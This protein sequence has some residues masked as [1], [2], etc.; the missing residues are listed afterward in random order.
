MLTTVAIVNWGHNEEGFVAL[1]NYCPALAT[2]DVTLAGCLGADAS[3]TDRTLIALGKGCPKLTKVHFGA[4]ENVIGDLSTV[5]DV[6]LR[7]LAER[8]RKL[9]SVS[10]VLKESMRDV[11]AVILPK[12]RI[13]FYDN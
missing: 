12:A 8:Y 1:A 2:L 13:E 10:L 3:L 6:G 11:V 4:G 7:A 5:S 9:E